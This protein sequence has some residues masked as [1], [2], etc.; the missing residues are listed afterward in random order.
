MSIADNL[1]LILEARYGRDVRQ[2]IHDAIHDCYQDGKVGAIDLIA[3]EKIDDVESDV[4]DI[5]DTALFA[6][7]EYPE[8]NTDDKTIIGGVNEIKAINENVA[9]SHK[10]LTFNGLEDLGLSVDTPDISL[11]MIASAMF[12]RGNSEL[13]FRV[14][15]AD[16][17]SLLA[18]G[19]IPINAGGVMRITCH[20]RSNAIYIT[21]AGDLYT[22]ACA[23]Y[24]DAW[25][26]W[27]YKTAGSQIGKTVT[28]DELQY[29]AGFTTS[30]K[31]RFY[32]TIPSLN[33]MIYKTVNI[34]G[35][36]SMGIRN[37]DKS[38]FSGINP[39]TSADWTVTTTT[40]HLGTTVVLQYK[41]DVSN[42]LQNSSCGISF[43]LKG[44]ATLY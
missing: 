12:E 1:R 4:N 8:L 32:F 28:L 40:N 25:G 16:R 17:A 13:I 3:R 33:T 5:L 10:I 11:P 29:L 22:N 26:G 6:L 23:N 14:M 21:D 2:A 43:R 35:M 15:S 39:V 38:L 24:Y 36:E 30:N 42:I 7:A 44:T 34:T 9:E 20:S 41:S 31:D 37:N 27:S 19:V 18:G